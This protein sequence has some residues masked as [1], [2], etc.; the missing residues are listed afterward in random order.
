M[1]FLD[2]FF[3]PPT[4]S[5]FLFGPRGTGKSTWLKHYYPDALRI[6]LLLPDEYRQYQAK[7]ERLKTILSAYPEKKT[8]IID[9]IQRVPELLNMV[10][11]L[12]EENKSYQFILT[13]SSARKLKRA[14]TD[15][16]AGRAVVR[17]FFPFLA[18]ELQDQ[19]NLSKALSIGLVPLIWTA[20]SP[21][22]TLASYIQV[23]IEQEVQVE[24][25]IRNM[26]SFTRFLE[27]ISFSHASLLNMSNIARE[28]GVGV[29]TIEGYLSVLEDLLVS[30]YLPVFTKRAQRALISHPKYYFFDTGIFQEL[31]PKNVLDSDS[32][33]NGLALEG[34]IAQHLRHW[35]MSCSKKHQLYF[36]RTKTGLEVDFIVY[37]ETEFKAIEVKNNSI[38]HPKDLHALKAFSKE[39]PECQSILVYRGNYR[40]K[41]ENILCIP[42][43]EFLLSI[44]V[45]A[46]LMPA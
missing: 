36:W 40:Q 32:E 29:K 5:Y 7:P 15:L 28:C 30:F 3:L 11:Y 10:H 6:D 24:G 14:G 17:Y 19:F 26:G 25:L 18:S 37:G 46:D 34:L 33:K 35:C 13:G 38:I 12:I 22:D 16:L 41:I 27:V 20:A 31:R 23:Y 2:R 4:D 9:E 42:A 44:Q 45:G 21:K 43:E 39:Y 1:E 8:V